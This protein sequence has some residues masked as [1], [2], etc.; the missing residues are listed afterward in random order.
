MPHYLLD[1]LSHYWPAVTLAL[2]I[3]IYA[4]R[5]GGWVGVTRVQISHIN[6]K[7]DKLADD[8]KALNTRVDKLYDRLFLRPSQSVTQSLSPISLSDYGKKISQD[9]DAPSLAK[10]YVNVLQDKSVGMNPYQIQEL[11]FAFDRDE[12]I[13]DMEEHDKDN[14]TKVTTCAFQEGIAVE[15]ITRVIGILMRDILLEQAGHAHTAVDDH[16]PRASDS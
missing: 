12:L 10:Q 16:A 15:T 4:W 7:I 13:K 6:E 5:A 9:I 2:A 11:C 8:F 3:V 1:M 14:F